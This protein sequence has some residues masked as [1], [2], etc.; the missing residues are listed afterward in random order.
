[1]RR[2]LQW[3]LC[4]SI[5]VTVIADYNIHTVTIMWRIHCWISIYD[6]YSA[7]WHESEEDCRQYTGSY[8]LIDVEVCLCLFEYHINSGIDIMVCKLWVVSGIFQMKL[9][10]LL[11]EVW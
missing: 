8:H 7:S 2:Q 1:M 5:S 6:H 10:E 9:Y 11:L 4:N 3:Y